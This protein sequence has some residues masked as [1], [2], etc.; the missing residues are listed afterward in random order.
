M[1]WQPYHSKP[2][3]FEEIEEEWIR[4]HPD[5]PIVQARKN[6]RQW[7]DQKGYPAIFDKGG[8]EPTNE[9]LIGFVKGIPLHVK[10]VH[11][12][13]FIDEIKFLVS[14]EADNRFEA[15]YNG[16]KDGINIIMRGKRWKPLPIVQAYVIEHK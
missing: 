15:S 8:W 7:W 3:T 11:E 5:A 16:V 9:E 12:E 13:G 10:V 2:V 1:S 14:T 6:A 4:R